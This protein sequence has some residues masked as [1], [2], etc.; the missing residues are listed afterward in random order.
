MQVQPLWP[1]I[2]PE[3]FFGLA[4]KIV[5]IIKP[6]T[7]VDP[8]AILLQILTMFGNAVGRHPYYP[9]GASRHYMNLF[10][11][12]VGTTGHAR[13]GMSYDFAKRLICHAA[14]EWEERISTGLSSGE[15]LIWAVRDPSYTTDKDGQQVCVDPGAEDKCLFVY[16]PE[17]AKVLSAVTRQGNNLSDNLRQAWDGQRLQTLVSGRQKA[18]IVAQEA[19][20]SVIAHITVE[21]LRRKLTETEMCNGFANRFLWCCVRRAQLLP[22][23]GTYPAKK[24]APL[25]SKL[26]QAVRKAQKM[27]RMKRTKQAQELWHTVYEKLSEEKSGLLGAITA[28]AEAQVT[29]L[30]CLYALLDQSATIKSYHLKAALALWNYCEASAAYIFGDAT[31]NLLANKILVKLREV[32]PKGLTRNGLYNSKVTGDFREITRHPD[33]A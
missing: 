26:K 6:E 30:S 27:S 17:F 24:L 9:V 10:G 13:K 3:A 2:A 8:V 31:G 16:E 33:I 22:D 19:H 18:P 15:G 4:G 32:H 25:L 1:E 12:L 7:E 5:E 14:P 11:C 23:G 29:R 20:I 28:R 21:E